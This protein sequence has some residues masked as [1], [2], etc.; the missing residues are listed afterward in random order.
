VKEAAAAHYNRHVI[1]MISE[2]LQLISTAYAELDPE[3]ASELGEDCL[4]KP[5]H[6]NHP[7]AVWARAH[8]NNLEWL[9][10]LGLALCAEY[11]RRFSDADEPPKK[12]AVEE[13]LLKLS[14]RCPRFADKLPPLNEF[15]VT[16]PPQC[17]PDK[18]KVPGDAVSAYRAYY[19]GEEKV[20]LRWW[21]PAGLRVELDDRDCFTPPM[22]AGMSV[23]PQKNFLDKLSRIQRASKRCADVDERSRKRASTHHLTV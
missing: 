23:T 16:E 7:C 3:L 21:R 14:G 2:T 20:S 5:T 6:K 18:Y 15:G 4:W 11:T 12:H 10:A 22:F 8:P 19:A 1:K 17:M 9:V 13:R